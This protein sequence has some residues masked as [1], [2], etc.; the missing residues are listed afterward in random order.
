VSGR[1]RHLATEIAA[2]NQSQAMANLLAIR[3]GREWIAPTL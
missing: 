3:N 2:P 1:L